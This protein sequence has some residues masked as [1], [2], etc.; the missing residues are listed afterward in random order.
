LRS[1]V[2]LGDGWELDLWPRYVAELPSIGVGSYVDLTARL[3]WRPR[4][5]VD[6]SLIGQNLFDNRRR[7]FAPEFL[8]MTPTQVQRAVFGRL[9]VGF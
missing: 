7:E 5:G 1:L 4:K 2:D 3:G 8:S 9:T 6:L